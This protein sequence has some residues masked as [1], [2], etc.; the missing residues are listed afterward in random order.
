MQR[1]IV[2]L[3]LLVFQF[4]AFAIS[5]KDYE[6]IYNEGLQLYKLKNYEA[7][8]IKFKESIDEYPLHFNSYLKK[9]YTHYN[10][11]QY[12]EAI[13][14]IE[15]GFEFEPLDS[16]YFFMKAQS[17]DKLQK[18]DLAIYYINMAIKFNDEK[19]A[20]YTL[21]ANINLGLGKYQEAID[22]YDIVLSKEPEQY[23]IYYNRG[24]AEFNQKNQIKGCLDWAFAQEQN[25]N[26]K[27]MLHYKCSNIDLRPYE[28]EET[29]IKSIQKPKFSNDNENSFSNIIRNEIN[30][31]DECIEKLEQGVVVVKFTISSKG[32]LDKIEILNS[33]SKKLDSIAIQSIKQSANCWT[34]PAY[35]N[36]KAIDFNYIVPIRF[37]INEPYFNEQILLDSINKAK[38]LNDEYT[39]YLLLRKYQKLNPFNYEKALRLTYLSKKLNQPISNLI[40]VDYSKENAFFIDE[41]EDYSKTYKLYFDEYWRLSNKENAKYYTISNQYYNGHLGEYTAYTIDTIKFATG[42]YFQKQQEGLFVEFYKNGNPRCKMYFNNGLPINNLFLFFPTGELKHKIYINKNEFAFIE[43]NGIQG[44]SLLSGND[45]LWEFSNIQDE[46]KDSIHIVCQISLNKKTSNWK[47]YKGNKL[48]CEEFYLRGKFEHCHLYENKTT[49]DLEKPYINASHL[50]PLSA[51]YCREIQLAPTLKTETWTFIKN[52]APEIYSGLKRVIH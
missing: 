9:S 50:I 39:E 2:L 46:S 52:L 23:H 48:I 19:L 8:L 4:I 17:F 47:L 11:K 13:T 28:R 33:V 14:T 20:Y 40:V 27:K 7:A 34:S 5:A 22:D 35:S 25:N 30:Y 32:I 43:Y 1:F 38:L 49:I 6:E 18:Y 3:Y 36:S 42:G 29:K 26:C 51:F 15:K 24:I 37:R 12:D 41:V 31:P 16:R 44:N 21:R 10:L 45:I